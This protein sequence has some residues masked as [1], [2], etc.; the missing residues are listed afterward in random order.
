[1]EKIKEDI[2]DK[3][4]NKDK[5]T[6]IGIGLIILIVGLLG[7]VLMFIGFMIVLGI[8]LWILKEELDK[9]KDIKKDE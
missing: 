7:K 4:K 3:I 5:P 2:V 1:M 9:R 6:L 8:G